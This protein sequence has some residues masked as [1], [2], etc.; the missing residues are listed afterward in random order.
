MDPNDL[1]KF[2][3]LAVDFVDSQPDDTWMDAFFIKSDSYELTNCTCLLPTI[4]CR[5][6]VDEPHNVATSIKTDE[7][8]AI[9]ETKMGLQN[10]VILNSLRRKNEQRV[11]ANTQESITASAAAAAHSWAQIVSAAADRAPEAEARQQPAM[12][13]QIDG[14]V[15][16]TPSRNSNCPQSY[17]E[18]D[19]DNYSEG[20]QDREG[21]PLMR[22][23]G[24]ADKLPAWK[25][26]SVE[27]W[28]EYTVSLQAL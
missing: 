12:M 3:D 11:A 28:Q 4:I 20:A 24:K 5:S 21:R 6:I 2:T 10:Y 17:D 14:M 1:N 13:Q 26:S 22:P 9:F 27:R 19:Y 16:S 15:S 23:L 8:M 25:G 7:T 18:D